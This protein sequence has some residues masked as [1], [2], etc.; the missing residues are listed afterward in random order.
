MVNG[1][2]IRKLCAKVAN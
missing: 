2:V 1:K